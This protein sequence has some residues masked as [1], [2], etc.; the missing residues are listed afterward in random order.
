MKQVIDM[1]S[2]KKYP[3]AKLAYRLNKRASNLI[4]NEPDPMSEVIN[5]L[6]K[7]GLNYDEETINQ[8]I[9]KGKVECP[10]FII[11][12]GCKQEPVKLN[13]IK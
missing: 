7:D 4:N 2:E 13:E 9:I 8:L 6:K 12:D 11:G 10:F 1:L 3:H 5:D